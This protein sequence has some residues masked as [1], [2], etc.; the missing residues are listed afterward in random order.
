MVCTCCCR[1]PISHQGDNARGRRCV[2]ATRNLS[3]VDLN[4]AHFQWSNFFLNL[5]IMNQFSN[6]P[7][8][9]KCTTFSESTSACRSIS[10]QHLIDTRRQ[11]FVAG[12]LSQHFIHTTGLSPPLLAKQWL[13]MFSL[14]PALLLIRINVQ[15]IMCDSE[16][17]IYQHF[18]RPAHPG[19]LRRVGVEDLWSKLN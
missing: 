15:S 1:V 3:S 7:L 17:I 9:K 14:S 8:H 2:C 10:R 12:I 4:L 5:I 13:N 11:L 18:L 6:R 16:W 19:G